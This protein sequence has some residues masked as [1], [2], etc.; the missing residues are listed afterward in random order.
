MS[1]EEC[2]GAQRVPTKDYRKMSPWVHM[3]ECVSCSPDKG[4]ECI[5]IM[6]TDDRFQKTFIINIIIDT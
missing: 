5:R 6:Q 1:N 3:N 2:S 4:I